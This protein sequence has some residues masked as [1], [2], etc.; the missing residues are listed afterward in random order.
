[1]LCP[2][3]NR[4]FM[5]QASSQTHPLGPMQTIRGKRIV[6]VSQAEIDLNGRPHVWAGLY[7][8]LEIGVAL[9]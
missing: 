9:A 3:S 4:R 5:P 2:A 7:D 6:H 1:M 8:R